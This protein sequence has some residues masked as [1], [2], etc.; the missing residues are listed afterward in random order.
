MTQAQ[1]DYLAA[2]AGRAGH[3]SIAS[4]ALAMHNTLVLISDAQSG[5][6]GNM[7]YQALHGRR[8]V[9]R[10]SKAVAQRG[11]DHIDEQMTDAVASI[12]ASRPPADPIQ[13]GDQAAPEEGDWPRA[14]GSAARNQERY[15]CDWNSKPHRFCGGPNKREA[16][17]RSPQDEDH[18]A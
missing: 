4:Y 3:T 12:S 9:D 7:A 11:H 13:L 15:V 16:S 2:R 14:S 10:A 6:W 8:P 1:L 5:V 18:E 17:P